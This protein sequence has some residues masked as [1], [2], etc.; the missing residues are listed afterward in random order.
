MSV[1]TGPGAGWPGKL[2]MR[3]PKGEGGVG[4]GGGEGKVSLEGEILK[5]SVGLLDKRRARRRRPRRRRQATQPSPLTVTMATVARDRH[6]TDAAAAAARCQCRR[7]Q[8]TLRQPATPALHTLLVGR[9]G[10]DWGLR[11][12]G[13]TP[14]V[15]RP[16]VTG[17]DAA[18]PY[19][20]R[21]GRK[22]T[23]RLAFSNPLVL[24]LFLKRG[25]GH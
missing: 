6:A 21:R 10:V 13:A 7:H 24:D 2:P 1:V 12:G 11:G 17:V 14:G 3:V 15:R 22:Q 9:A 5:F 18:A 4:A 20:G 16:F 8:P 25:G 19:A 23:G